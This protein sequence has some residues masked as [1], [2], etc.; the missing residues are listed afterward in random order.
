MH[1]KRLI[2]VNRK[3]KTVT[4][5][6]NL[7]RLILNNKVEF[8][9]SRYAWIKKSLGLINRATEVHCAILT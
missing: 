4:E 3:G 9:W 8:F 7:R 1:I 6:T 5:Q 2:Q